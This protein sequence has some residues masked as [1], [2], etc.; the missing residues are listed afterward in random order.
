MAPTTGPQGSGLLHSVVAADGLAEV[1]ADRE[2]LAAGAE[3]VVHLLV[4]AS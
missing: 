3:V 4:D 2:S 1:P